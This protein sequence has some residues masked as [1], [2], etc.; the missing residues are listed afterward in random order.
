MPLY[1]LG[2]FGFLASSEL[3]LE[4]QSS[5]FNSG[6]F[7]LWDQRLALEWTYDNIV[8]FGGSPRNITVGGYSGGSYAAFLQLQ[9]DLSRPSEDQ[10]IRRVVFQSNGPGVQPVSL[11]SSQ[12]QFDRVLGLCEISM[13]SSPQDKLESLR[14][15]EHGTI[16]A[17]LSK[18]ENMDLIF[19]PILDND[20]VNATLCAIHNGSLASLALER[21]IKFLMGA[22]QSEENFY[23]IARVASC[24]DMLFRL[25]R[26]FPVRAVKAILPW[27]GVSDTPNSNTNWTEVNGRVFSDLQVHVP[28]RGL[29]SSLREAGVHL[30]AVSRYEI[31]WRVRSTALILSE[32]L[33]VTHG[34]DM[35]F[36]WFYNAKCGM[37]TKERDIIRTWLKPFAA[38]LRGDKEVDWGTRKITDVRVLDSDGIIRICPDKAW[39]QALSVWDT[40][41]GVLGEG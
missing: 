36:I 32:S 30:S 19:R 33:G 41:G 26:N 16:L 39:D 8:A 22:T 12:E 31:R 20:F 34:T 3:Q 7:G 35:F 1:R 11:Q 6:N 21:G 4:A 27:Y 17:K 14:G 5:G 23:G 37:S 9:Y 29:L 15:L 13:G 38:F 2:I 24:E 18:E 25:S 28:T 40:L 10:I